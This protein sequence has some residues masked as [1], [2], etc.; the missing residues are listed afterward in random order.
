MVA[1]L[2]SGV[3]SSQPFAISEKKSSK[4]LQAFEDI[5]NL[6]DSEEFIFHY[7]EVVEIERRFRS[8]ESHFSEAYY[9]L[10][11]LEKKLATFNFS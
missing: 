9:Q 1:M 7:R 11:D 6:N 5:E 4:L 3:E 10:L 8:V 2:D